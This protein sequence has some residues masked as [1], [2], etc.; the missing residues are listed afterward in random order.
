MQLYLDTLTSQCGVGDGRICVG[1]VEVEAVEVQPDEADLCLTFTD[2]EVAGGGGG[3]GP[4]GQILTVGPP[5]V[6]YE[7][8][9]HSETSST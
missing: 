7:I 9:T 4:V 2:L 5:T 1:L 3:F 6:C 8:T